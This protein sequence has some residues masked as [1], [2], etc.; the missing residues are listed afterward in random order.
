M[1]QCHYHRSRE[2]TCPHCQQTNLS[3]LPDPP[4]HSHSFTLG[5]A[6]GDISDLITRASRGVPIGASPDVDTTPA[7]ELREDMTTSLV[8]TPTL[9]N[10]PTASQ[11]TV[12]QSPEV[13]RESTT[14]SEEQSAPVAVATPESTTLPPSVPATVTQNT[15]RHTARSSSH[16]PPVLLDTAIC[17]L[18]V[19][20]FAMICRRVV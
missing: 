17:I 7:T 8:T 11:V 3:L 19:L 16:K 18:L 12:F 13:A 5:S 2:W 4:A 9:P 6:P 15:R 10:P 1:T 20:L 14:T